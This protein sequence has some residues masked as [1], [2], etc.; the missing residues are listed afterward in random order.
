MHCCQFPVRLF[1]LVQT[2]KLQAARRKQGVNLHLLGWN[3]IQY[4]VRISGFVMNTAQSRN[5]SVRQNVGPVST[6]LLL[7]CFF[8]N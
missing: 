2:K 5:E 6:I 1:R 7:W 3:G 4:F 8:K